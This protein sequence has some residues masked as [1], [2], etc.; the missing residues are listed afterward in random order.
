MVDELTHPG[1]DLRIVGRGRQDQLV[2]AEGILDGLRPVFSRQ[3]ADLDVGNPSCLQF[4]RQHLSRFL[5]VAVNGGVGDENAVGLSQIA[6]PGVIQVDVVSQ[7]FF[8]HG[9]VQRQNLLDLQTRR[10]FQDRLDLSTIL[11]DDAEVVAPRF[12]GPVLIH[13]QSAEL[14]EAVSGEQDLLGRLIGHHDF[15]PVNHGS[16][17]EVQLVLAQIQNV[18]VS[19]FDGLADLDVREVLSNHLEG[20]LVAYHYRLGV[21]LHEGLDGSGM[22]RLHV[23]DDQI[24]RSHAPQSQFDVLQP[25]L[26][27]PLVDGIHDRDL[28]IDDGVGIV[29]HTVGHDILALEQVDIVVVGADINDRV[30]DVSVH[31]NLLFSLYSAALA[32]FAHTQLL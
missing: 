26:S 12:A 11:A 25:L 18:A 20:L 32:A 8:Q 3:V 22:V 27:L 31:K 10:F 30:C 13:I 29:S 9:P 4:S 2:I 17:H 23:L 6:G 7:V 28:V 1:E 14:A 21:L 24:I 16:E 19:H 15:R 5:G